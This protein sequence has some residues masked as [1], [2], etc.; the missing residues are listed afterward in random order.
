MYTPHAVTLFNVTEDA[1]GKAV[2]NATL[3]VGVFLDIAKGAN[4]QNSGLES[5]DAA[6]LYIPIGIKAINC[7]T[8]KVQQFLSPKEY[9][10]EQD[11]SGYWTLRTS[12]TSSAV[13]CFF[14]KGIISEVATFKDINAKYNDVFRVSNVDTKDYGR[15]GMQHW[16]VGGK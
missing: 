1:L 3:L 11:T 12:G 4:V 8:G 16:E 10:R 14:A 15:A 5:A 13:D 7:V 6:T 9:A 2:V